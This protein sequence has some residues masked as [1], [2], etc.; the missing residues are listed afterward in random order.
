MYVL[1]KIRHG[2]SRVSI[3]ELWIEMDAE[4]RQRIIRALCNG[5]LL[6]EGRWFSAGHN[7]PYSEV[8]HPFSYISREAWYGQMFDTASADKPI[9]VCPD[10]DDPSQSFVDIQLINCEKLIEILD[11]D[12]DQRGPETNLAQLAVDGQKMSAKVWAAMAA[13][14]AQKRVPLSPSAI[15][16]ALL[17]R[18]DLWYHG[19]VDHRR[20]RGFAKTFIDEVKAFA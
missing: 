19:T 12:P 6:A 10:V 17:D 9:C 11:L 16:N 4:D 20:L 1:N 15:A 3:D 13:M 14:A 5:E 8:L 2:E 7:F 18:D